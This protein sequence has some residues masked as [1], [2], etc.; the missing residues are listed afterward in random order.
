MTVNLILPTG[1]QVVTRIEARAG[2]KVYPRGAV[3]V[4]TQAPL[5]NKHS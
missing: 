5:D 2:G 4:I 1:T 3:G